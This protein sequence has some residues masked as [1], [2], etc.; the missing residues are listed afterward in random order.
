MIGTNTVSSFQTLSGI[1]GATPIAPSAI[2]I[3]PIGGSTNP[4]LTMQ[5][6]VAAA[7][8]QILE[9][10]FTYKISGNP[11][12]HDM[13]TVSGTSSSGDGVATDVQNYCVG[14]VFGPDGV[15]GCTGPASGALV[16][17][18]DGTD[19]AVLPSLPLVA[20]TDDFT[21][22]G[23]TDGSASG[24]T[25]TDQLAATSAVPEPGTFLLA[26]FGLALAALAKVI[27]QN[28]IYF[29]LGIVYH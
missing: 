23:G 22:D 12:T 17:V 14:G 27:P 11:F 13:I 24:G 21:L 26:G 3:N 10:L 18:G 25:F 2:S 9:A 19:Q 4:G 8:N 20:V 1:T 28:K 15:A 6:N 7:A 29:L 16:S 5:V